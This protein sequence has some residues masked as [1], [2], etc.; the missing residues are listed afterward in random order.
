MGKTKELNL[1]NGDS[2]MV[3]FYNYSI[4]NFTFRQ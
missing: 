4:F 3:H 2:K 1:G